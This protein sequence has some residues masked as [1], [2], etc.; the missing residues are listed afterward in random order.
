MEK[1]CTNTIDCSIRS[2]W[3]AVQ[4]VVDQVLARTTLQDLVSNEQDM[5][6]WVGNL[7]H[8]SSAAPVPI[9]PPPGP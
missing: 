3:R 6:Q 8:I 2:L 9:S 5:S 4:L 7:V 1:V